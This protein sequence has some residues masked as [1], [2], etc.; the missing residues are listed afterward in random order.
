MVQWSVS[1]AAQGTATSMEPTKPSTSSSGD[2]MDSSTS[3]TDCKETGTKL[4][5]ENPQPGRL[6]AAVSLVGLLYLGE[7]PRSPRSSLCYLQ[8]LPL[9]KLIP[10]LAQSLRHY[11]K[12]E[13]G[14]LKD[15]EEKARRRGSGT[16]HLLVK[17]WQKVQCPPLTLVQQTQAR[18]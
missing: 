17:A 9:L 13:E 3:F 11:F 8:G 16:T 4:A 15:E 12:P 18:A 10:T 2:S 7:Q 6:P 14:E 1:S 5:Q